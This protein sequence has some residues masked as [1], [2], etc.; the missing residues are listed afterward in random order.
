MN[1][2]ISI[3]NVTSN[4]E[5]DGR[6]FEL[7]R[8]RYCLKVFDPI[9]SSWPPSVNDTLPRTRVQHCLVLTNDTFTFHRLFHRCSPAVNNA[10]LGAC[11]SFTAKSSVYS[12]RDTEKAI[13]VVGSSHRSESLSVLCSFFLVEWPA[14]PPPVQLCARFCGHSCAQCQTLPQRLHFVLSFSS[15]TSARNFRVAGFAADFDGRP[16]P[17]RSF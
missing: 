15:S 13:H 12:Q 6:F 3:W 10:V 16:N 5:T 17:R 11:E 14:R 4:A 1:N 2:L 7:N 9:S 8:S